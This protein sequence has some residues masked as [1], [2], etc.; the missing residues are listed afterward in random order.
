[1]KLS[2]EPLVRHG[3]CRTPVIVGSS[4]VFRRRGVGDKA[5]FNQGECQLS[6]MGDCARLGLRWWNEPASGSALDDEKFIEPAFQCAIEEG[7]VLEGARPISFGTL[8]S[9]R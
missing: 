5:T 6:K 7:N 4:C 1:M 2:S 9:G 8:A 3:A